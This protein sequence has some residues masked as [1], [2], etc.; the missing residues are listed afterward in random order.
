MA[1]TS[2][3]QPE[4]SA[5]NARPE[6]DGDFADGGDAPIKQNDKEEDQTAG[7]GFGLQRGER[8]EISS[9]TSKTDGSRSDGKRSLHKSL[10]N[11]QERHQTAP[12]SGAVCFAQKDVGSACARHGC[13]QLRPD[14]GVEC[15]QGR[16]S[17]PGDESLRP[18]HRFDH[19]R[20]DHERTD[21]DNLDHV[22]RYGLFEAEAALEAG[23][24]FYGGAPVSGGRHHVGGRGHAAE[25]SKC[26]ARRLTR[27]SRNEADGFFAACT[28][29]V[30]NSSRTA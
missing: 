19:K 15:G 26:G 4:K 10:P 8:M 30:C 5:D 9:V 25:N 14:K 18:A 22:E 23:C 17:D 29:S 21:A 1:C 20:R 28:I 3:D 7:D 11:E 24:L 16:S 27:N 13:A 12:T 2:P 6:E